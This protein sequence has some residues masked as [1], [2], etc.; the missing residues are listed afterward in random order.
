MTNT[1][2]VVEMNNAMNF[3][4]EGENVSVEKVAKFDKLKKSEKFALVVNILEQIENSENLVDFIEKEIVMNDN[5]NAKRSE[6]KKMSKTQ[7]E[8]A[9]SVKA[10]VEYMATQESP[11]S[12][13]TILDNLEIE[14]SSTQKATSLL[15]QAMDTGEVVKSD[16]KVKEDGKTRVGYIH[17]NFADTDE[18]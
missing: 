15:K 18:E 5:R 11:L 13:V 3:K 17:I 10:I 6:N 1:N 7:I 8:N 9:E 16:K 14:Y 12:S 2:T 4:F